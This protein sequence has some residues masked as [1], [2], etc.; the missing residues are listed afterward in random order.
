MLEAC[1][2]TS[3]HHLSIDAYSTPETP[4]ITYAMSAR[5]YMKNPRFSIAPSQGRGFLTNVHDLVRDSLWEKLEKFRML[6]QGWDGYGAEPVY[7]SCI[8]NVMKFVEMLS[9]NVPSPDITP[10]P[11][12]TL[13]LDWEKGGEFLSIEIGETK[14]STFYETSDGGVEMDAGELALDTAPSVVDD[15]FRVMFP[16]RYYIIPASSQEYVLDVSLSL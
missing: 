4:G 2:L 5:N 7:E 9:D 1:M 10:N 14:Y 13:T 15:A 12:G 3:T 6:P 16:R 11:N 8:S